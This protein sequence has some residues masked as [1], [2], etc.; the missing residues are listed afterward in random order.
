MK[1]GVTNDHGVSKRTQYRIIDQH[2]SLQL[3]YDQHCVGKKCY[4]QFRIHLDGNLISLYNDVT[5]QYAQERFMEHVRTYVK[6]L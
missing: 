3:L 4:H 2:G 1:M 5:I 6:T